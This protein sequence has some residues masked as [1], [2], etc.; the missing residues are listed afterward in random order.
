MLV[1]PFH[2][3]IIHKSLKVEAVQVSTDRR[4]D[5]T[6]LHRKKYQEAI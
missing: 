6:Y 5:K 4:M 1:Y 3:S 2:N